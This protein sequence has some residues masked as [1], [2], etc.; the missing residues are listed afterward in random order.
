M[1]SLQLTISK[2]TKLWPKTLINT[3]FE[4]ISL[5]A[6][7]SI[8]QAPG[9]W[10]RSK[11]VCKMSKIRKELW[12]KIKWR[13]G[14]ILKKKGIL[15]FQTI[16]KLWK[17]ASKRTNWPSQPKFIKL[18]KSLVMHLISKSIQCISREKHCSCRQ[19]LVIIGSEDRKNLV[20]A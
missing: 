20:E 1:S 17:K 12:L 15:S 6:R 16:S 10:L 9:T 13:N 3:K 18:L 11:L 5:K 19:P 7:I 14:T 2:V 8:K 4:S